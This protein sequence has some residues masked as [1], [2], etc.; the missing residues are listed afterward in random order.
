MLENKEVLDQEQ[1]EVE[2]KEVN[3]IKVEPEANVDETTKNDDKQV[4]NDNQ[5]ESQEEVK[6]ERP[7]YQM[8]VKKH[9]AEK[10]KWKEKEAEYQQK[11]QEMEEKLQSAGSR[12][13]T[14]DEVSKFAEEQGL[15]AK[16][17]AGLISLA[18]KKLSNKIAPNEKIEKLLKE[19]EISEAKR[20]VE[21]DFDSRVVER[22]KKDYPTATQ[23]HINK[24]KKEIT[25]LAFTSKYNTYDVADIY[26]VN[27]DK[28]EFKDNYTAESSSG[29]S[30][31]YVNYDNV[32][33]KDIE[34]M[35]PQE[36]FKYSEYKARKQG[37]WSK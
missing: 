26:L 1:K 28:Y 16:A 21:V 37:K 15:D 36:Y 30:A 22:I 10:A 25:E 24:I 8:P 27:R 9:Q 19:Q 33:D 13:L 32:S 14:D 18:E 11:L 23:E 35:S 4:D 29:K 2:A 20:Q 7:V 17:V 31:E 34:S 6:P 12:D 5:D 3:E